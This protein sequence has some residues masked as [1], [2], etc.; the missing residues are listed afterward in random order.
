MG[1][2]FQALNL[3]QDHMRDMWNAGYIEGFI[4]KLHACNV[5]MAFQKTGMF[6]LRFA[7]SRCGAVT[8][9]YIMENLD[10]GFLE[11]NDGKALEQ[12]SMGQILFQNSGQSSLVANL[13]QLVTLQSDGTPKVVDKQQLE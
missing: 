9:G 3:T 4:S 2:Y 13:S 6:L 12:T 7:D 11:P 1:W 8:I 10:P 5:L